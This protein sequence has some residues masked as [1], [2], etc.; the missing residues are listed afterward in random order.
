MRS[1]WVLVCLAAS[2]CL[3]P[4][5]GLVWGDGAPFVDDTDAADTAPADT[6]ADDSAVEETGDTDLAVDSG[7]TEPFLDVACADPPTPGCRAASGSLG[8]PPRYIPAGSFTMG[9]VDPRDVAGGL[10]SCSRS[11][12]LPTR[13]VMLTKAFWMMESELTQGTWTALGFTNPSNFTTS[14]TNRPV[15]TVNWWEALEAANE[16]SRRD[17]LPECYTLTGCNSNAIGADREC[18]GVTVASASGHPK[19]CEG[20]RLPTEAEWEYAARAGT[21]FPYAGGGDVNQVAWYSS[22][23]GIQTKP[24]CTTPTPRNAWGLCDMGGN[25]LEWA[26]DWYANSYTGAAT[27]DPEGSASGSSRVRRGGYW[28]NDAR[29]VRVAL[30]SGNTPGDRGSNYGF[31]LVRSSLDP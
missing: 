23:S 21:S 10:T 6:S 30:R 26:W 18:T 12:E 8:T 19:D 9:C 1:S 28:V 27:T 5:D 4:A 13:T 14:G 24:V 25:V 11:D 16:A 31:R 2:A 7:E 20:W 29:S 3:L 22:N 17:G 15:E